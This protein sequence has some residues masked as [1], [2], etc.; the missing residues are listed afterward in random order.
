MVRNYRFA[1]VRKDKCNPSSCGELCIKLCPINRSGE[2]CISKTDDGKVRIDE[3][4]CTGCQICSNRCPFGAISIINLPKPPDKKP[5][6]RYGENGFSL[7]GLISPV[8]GKIV[9]VIGRNGIG[10]S[11]SLNILSGE[12]K[13]N[14]GDVNKSL[15]D[16]E[17]K[18]KL[19]DFFKGTESQLFFKK[20]IS[21]ELRISYKPQMV[22]KIPKFFKG[23]VRELLSKSDEKNNLEEVSKKLGFNNILDNDIGKISGGEL[24]KV[25][26]AATSLK[27][28]DLYMFDEPSSY[29]DV[30]ERLR[31]AQYIRELISEDNAIIV[32]DHDLIMQDYVSDLVVIMYGKEGTYGVV[33]NVMNARNGINTFLNGY[34]KTENVQFRDYK[35]KYENLKENINKKSEAVVE[36]NGISKR[37]GHFTIESKKG[38]VSEKDIIGVVGKNGI[39]K[40][41]FMKILA[42]VMKP[43]KGIINGSPKVSYKPQQIPTSSTFVKELFKEVRNEVN[44]LV[45]KPLNIKDMMN[46]RLNELSGGELQKV[47]IAYALSREADIYLLDE[48]SAYLDVEERLNTAKV[49]KGYINNVSKAIVIIDH[50]LMFL[51]YFSEKIIVF[52]GEAAVHG[53]AIEPMDKRKGMN[54][55]LKDLGISFRRD[56]DS[57]RPKVNKVGSQ[58]DKS[59]KAKGEYFY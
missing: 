5:I 2:Q 51:D 45:M 53:E 25:A 31:I 40:T 49:I 30:S 24:Q 8:F 39:G 36:W 37:L 10:K 21:G 27:K 35:I 14:F 43:D 17:Y 6:H 13:P 32:V 12:I 29:L 54:L 52:I 3:V 57:R 20:M 58:L 28:A 42:G 11:T 46:K 56:I 23:T 44:N 33:S 15:S 38:V 34:I 9:G 7:F 18:Q 19:M 16:K 4:L 22:E 1:V 59:Q 41:T 26:I 47:A 50:D 48:P 55:F